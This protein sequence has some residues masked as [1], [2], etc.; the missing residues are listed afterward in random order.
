MP[1]RQVRRA[2]GSMVPVK[3]AKFPLVKLD[4]SN[5]HLGGLRAGV[6]TGWGVLVCERAHLSVS[7]SVVEFCHQAVSVVDWC[8][9]VIKDCDLRFNGNALWFGNKAEVRMYRSNISETLAAFSLRTF[10]DRGT[11]C[12]SK[13][14]DEDDGREARLSI[15]SC[16]IDSPVAFEGNLEP[17]TF[18]NHSSSWRLPRTPPNA[19]LVRPMLPFIEDPLAYHLKNIGR[20][21]LSDIATFGADPSLVVPNPLYG[22]RPGE[23]AGNAT[24]VVDAGDESS[25]LP[26]SRG[27]A[28]EVSSSRSEFDLYEGPERKGVQIHSE[29]F[30]SDPISIS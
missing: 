4:I 30:S 29:D 8:R 15:D 5:C 25:S 9:A 1:R 16:A 21:D 27:Q 17:G 7:A 12:M 19:S 26:A 22:K 6:P 3:Y 18:L 11:K 10:S 13:E 14:Q 28:R 20:D 24:A 2:D 23:D